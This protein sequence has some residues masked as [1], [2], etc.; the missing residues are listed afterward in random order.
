MIKKHFNKIIA[1]GI[2]ATSVLAIN[3][4]G[5]SAEWKQDSNGWWNTEGSSYS[6]GWK[7]KLPFTIIKLSSPM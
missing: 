1:L 5:A 6:I 2:V 4:I 7:L 3:P